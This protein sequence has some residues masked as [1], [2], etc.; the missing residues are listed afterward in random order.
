MP[1][2]PQA[3]RPSASPSAVSQRF[4][5]RIESMPASDSSGPRND[6]LD[7]VLTR[8]AAEAT[9]GRAGASLSAVRLTSHDTLLVLFCASML[10]V[11]LHFV[12]STTFRAYTRCV[13]DGCLLCRLGN[14]A[15][16]RD[17]VP[18]YD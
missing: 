8:W 3:A 4:L 2:P 9:V 7:N 17:L 5:Q 6:K 16:Q 10:R 13:G 18:V 14:Q 11:M 15:E 12:N 1:V